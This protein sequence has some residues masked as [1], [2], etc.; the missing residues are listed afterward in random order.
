MVVNGSNHATLPAMRD[1]DDTDDDKKEKK[2]QW[3]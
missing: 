2:K 3:C 1:D